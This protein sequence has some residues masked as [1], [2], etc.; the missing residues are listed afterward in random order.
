MMKR[1]L[2]SKEKETPAEG[3][4]TAWMNSRYKEPNAKRDLLKSKPRLTWRNL[5]AKAKI[6]AGMPAR[7]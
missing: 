4:W 7:R 6:M 3:Y 5:A 2:K 1:A